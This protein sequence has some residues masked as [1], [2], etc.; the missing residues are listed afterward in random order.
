M[1]SLDY[2]SLHRLKTITGAISSTVQMSYDRV[3][4]LTRRDE[5]NGDF[6]EYFYAMGWNCLTDEIQYVS[7]CPE[8]GLGIPTMATDS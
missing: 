2:D 1:R 3:S 8:S 4:N 5:R 6:I 7:W